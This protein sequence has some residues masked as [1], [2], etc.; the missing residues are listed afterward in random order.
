VDATESRRVAGLV[1]QV[2][3][4]SADEVLQRVGHALGPALLTGDE[5]HARRVA[6]LTVYL[7]QH[8]A[9]RDLVAQGRE[10]L[11]APSGWRWW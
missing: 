2:V 10:V 7:R 9:E 3:A 8:H 11:E 1:R 5:E 6:D 4:D